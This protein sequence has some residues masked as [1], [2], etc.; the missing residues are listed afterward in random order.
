M[1]K[2][3][4][5]VFKVLRE[6]RATIGFAESCTGGVLS[7]AVTEV[8]GSSEFFMGSIV[9]YANQAKVDLLGVQMEDI[10][11]HGAVSQ[12]VA[13]KMARGAQ[14]RLNCTFAL[15]ITGI[16]GPGGGTP[17]KPVGTVC[18]GLAGTNFVVSERKQF[19]GN[20]SEIRKQSAEHALQMLLVKLKH[21]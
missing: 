12:A 1:E 8:P 20:R 13:E 5:E 11:A 16:A 3:I 19:N 10:R 17:E 18:F 7:A 14:H 6:K 15:A 21:A 4:L 9:S 2:L